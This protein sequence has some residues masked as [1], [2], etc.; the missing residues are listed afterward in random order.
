MGQISDKKFYLNIIRLILAALFLRF[1]IMPFSFHGSDIFSLNY[2]PFKLIEYK[3]FDPYLV[4]DQRGIYLPYPPGIFYILASF[5]FLFKPFLLN[6]KELFSVFTAWNF[7]CG[8][9]TVNFADILINNQL[10]RT[11]FLFKIP[12]LVSDFV[13]GFV[14]FQLLKKDKR[15]VFTAL[16]MWALNPFVLHSVYALGQFD[17]IVAMFIMLSLLAITIERP[18][19]AIACLSLG[20]SIKI[21]PLLFIPPLVIILG[22]TLKEKSQLT[23]VALATFIIPFLPIFFIIS[24]LTVMNILN[25]GSNIE[26]PAFRKGAFFVVYSLFLAILFLFKKKDIDKIQ[27]A[28]LCFVSILLLFYSLFRVN[29]RYFVWITPLLILLVVENRIFWIY[30]SIFLITLFELR[31]AGNSQQWGLFA[32]LHPEFFSSLPIADSYFNLAVNVKYIHQVMYRLFVI[33]SLTMVVHMILVNARLLKFFWPFYI[34][35]EKK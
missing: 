2:F 33:S 23:L 10:F 21:I 27:I 8:A 12:Y 28:T 7:T 11:L 32:A 1:L 25:L 16:L 22:K 31:T 30:V 5:L 15:K 4:P 19:L 24:K 26:I 6:L 3:I 35:N 17:I 29:L 34:K 14:I 13:I 20:G 9:N 18:Y